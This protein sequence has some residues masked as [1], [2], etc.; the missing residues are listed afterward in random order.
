[1]IKDSI[2]V[3]NFLIAHFKQLIKYCANPDPEKLR[4]MWNLH[5]PG[6]MRILHPALTATPC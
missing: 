5:K 1:M 2:N 4:A 6:F 3:V